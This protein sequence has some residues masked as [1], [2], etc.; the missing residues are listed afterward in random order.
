M[1]QGG[2][3]MTTKRYLMPAVLLGAALAGT[4]AAQ[5]GPQPALRPVV[6][7]HLNAAQK[8][9]EAENYQCA[10]DRLGDVQRFDDLS[11]YEQAQLWNFYAF[12][13]FEQDD[14]AG[15][16][17]AYEQVLEQRDLPRPMERTS[18]YSVASLYAQ[19]EEY[20]SAL[21]AID[22]WFAITDDP[23]AEPY[24]LYAQ[25][26]YQTGEYDAGVARIERA[27]ALAT[28]RG[29]EIEEGWYQLLTTMSYERKDYE[30][31]IDTLE[32]MIRRWPKRD[33]FVQ[34]AGMHGLLGNEDRQ[35]DLYEGAYGAGWLTKESELK[36][37][38][39]LLLEAGR[40]T[41]AVE[42]LH[43]GFDDGT[44]EPSVANRELLSRAQIQ[45]MEMAKRL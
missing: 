1:Y 21:G 35:L 27:I 15:A 40:P 10:L 24:V 36:S 33:Y 45:Q 26:L 42:V 44:I 18:L 5:Q 43:R 4:A 6:Y 28:E 14:I 17:A 8:C 29:L 3:D 2:Q 32:T 25:M 19:Q 13:Y 12:L 38:A 34:L 39:W 7:E 31:V 22:R 20:E 9:V 41:R 16:I 37:L 23:T 30:R 11:S